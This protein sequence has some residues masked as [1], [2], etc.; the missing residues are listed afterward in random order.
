MFD[1]SKEVTGY[2]NDKVTLPSAE[3][4]EMRE[5]RNA[6]RDRLTNGLKK[7][8]KPA[9]EEFV[10]QGSYSMKTMIQQ[11]DRDYDI[12]DGVYFLKS[13]LVGD[14]GA[15]LSALDARKLVRDAVD[16]GS[17]KTPPEVRNNCVRVFYEAGYHVDLPVYRRFEQI[18][19]WGITDIINELAST[20][21]TR[22]DARDVS[23][24]FGDNNKQLSPD[25]TNGRQ[26]RRVTRLIKMYAK[27]RP[28]W[29]GTLL[30]GF[31][32]TALVVECFRAADGRDDKAFRET[33]IAIKNRLAINLVVAHPVTPNSFITDGADDPKA[34][35]LMEKLDEAIESLKPLDD[36]N[37]T[38]TEAL[39]CWDKVFYT[40]YFSS[41]S[42]EKTSKTNSSALD[43]GMLRTKVIETNAMVSVNKGGGGTYA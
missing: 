41:L 6:N 15:E 25:S 7:K 36:T 40:D 2:H 19:F 8:E 10:S 31:G 20:N 5:R 43:A 17:F 3:Q 11:P 13:N 42:D 37:T 27:S 22:S 29:S 23:K 21:W 33:I 38:R 28:S 39:A 32:I 9:V 1:C 34:R 12:D 30:S 18:T 4:T 16:D 35:K 26:L 24:W 14:R